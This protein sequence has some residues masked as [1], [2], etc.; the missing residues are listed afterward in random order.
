LIPRS[1]IGPGVPGDVDPA[2]S[3]KI[4]RIVIAYRVGDVLN[5]PHLSDNC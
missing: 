5:R 1:P 3:E 4:A 2:D